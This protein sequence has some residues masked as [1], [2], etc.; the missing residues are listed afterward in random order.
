MECWLAM[1]SKDF[2]H[3]NYLFNNA[4]RSIYQALVVAILSLALVIITAIIGDT[5]LASLNLWHLTNAGQSALAAWPVALGGSWHIGLDAS[6]PTIPFLS[7]QLT[8]PVFTGTV[9]VPWNLLT[10]EAIATSGLTAWLW[11]PTNPLLLGVA[12]FII[13]VLLGLLSSTIISH[14]PGVDLAGGITH[15]LVRGGIHPKITAEPKVNVFWFLSALGIGAAASLGTLVNRRSRYRLAGVRFKETVLIICAAL[16]S[17]GLAGG[18]SWLVVLITGI[19]DPAF[20]R[21]TILKPPLWLLGGPAWMVQALGTASGATLHVQATVVG[22]GLSHYL[23]ILTTDHVALVPSLVLALVIVISGFVGG[24]WWRQRSA[25]VG[26][27]RSWLIGLVFGAT[28][29]VLVIGSVF[30]VD[31]RLASDI[32]SF[33]KGLV[34]GLLGL[35]P[36]LGSFISGLAGGALS[37][38]HSKGIE[39]RWGVSPLGT[40]LGSILLSGIGALAGSVSVRTQ[41][42]GHIARSKE[43]LAKPFDVGFHSPSA[44]PGFRQE[45]PI[46]DDIS[47]TPI[48]DDSENAPPSVKDMEGM[49]VPRSV[50]PLCRNV[51]TGGTKICR[52]CGSRL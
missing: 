2:S 6:L 49:L 29:A 24:R 38:A 50:C 26:R 30:S 8:I 14:I 13:T 22:I 10:M 19:V 28:L 4:S 44:P 45:S 41:R 27:A 52:E 25:A 34:G 47:Q 20:A 3:S 37:A 35:I 31:V 17:L 21:A 18:I 5:W 40:V 36:F 11:R 1:N 48:E 9:G 51:E 7:K 12:S 15:Q 46:T 33:A 16:V 43:Q 39:V 32:T 42:P 23:G